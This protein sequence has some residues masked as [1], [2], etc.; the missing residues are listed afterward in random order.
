[1]TDTGYEVEI[2]KPNVVGRCRTCAA[3]PWGACLWAFGVVSPTGIEHIGVDYG[4]T[5]CGRDATGLKWW[6]PL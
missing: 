1:M 6:W 4:K 2:P 3:T 5:A